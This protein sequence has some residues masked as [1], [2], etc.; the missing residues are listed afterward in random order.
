MSELQKRQLR[1]WAN[2]GFDKLTQA[3]ITIM[4]ALLLAGGKE[5]YKGLK[6][7]EAAIAED[8]KAHAV[9]DEVNKAFDHRLTQLEKK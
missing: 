9:Q 2:V 3:A 4:V 1:R 7:I 6:N 5:A 8:K